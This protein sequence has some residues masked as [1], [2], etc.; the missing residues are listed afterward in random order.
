MSFEQISEFQQGQRETVSKLGAFFS[1][2]NTLTQ[3]IEKG[4]ETLLNEKIRRLQPV[5]GE[6][7]NDSLSIYKFLNSHHYSA[8]HQSINRPI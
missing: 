3:P 1:Q 6:F 8:Y 4:D 5:V 7:M 2:L